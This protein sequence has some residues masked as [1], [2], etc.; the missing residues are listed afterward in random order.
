M[1]DEDIFLR[2][3]VDKGEGPPPDTDLRLRSQDDKEA[4]L[5]NN[6]TFFGMNQ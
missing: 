6:A 2:S 5:K 4:V 1:P 3:D